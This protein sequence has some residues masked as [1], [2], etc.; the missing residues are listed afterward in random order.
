MATQ[1]QL[2]GNHMP[3]P[4]L[5]ERKDNNQVV[6]FS[7]ETNFVERKKWKLQAAVRK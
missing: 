1:M 5:L 6:S 7:K 4:G 3:P 2:E